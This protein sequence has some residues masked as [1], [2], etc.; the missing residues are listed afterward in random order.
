MSDF[1]TMKDR[2]LMGGAMDYEKLSDMR[3]IEDYTGWRGHMK[4]LKPIKAKCGCC[5]CPDCG[6]LHDE[7][8]CEHN[9]IVGIL[10]GAGG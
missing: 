5:C 3:V 6:H 10:K 1:D 7:C 8:V 2:Y 9:E 4:Q